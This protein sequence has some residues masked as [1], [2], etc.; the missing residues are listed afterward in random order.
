VKGKN[1]IGTVTVTVS[2]TD[3]VHQ[4]LEELV[5]TGLYGKNAAE[6]AER[7]I[8]LGLEELFKSGRVQQKPVT[9]SNA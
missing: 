9:D 1:L 6:A 3:P 7:V 5:E 2:T 4:Y 8:V